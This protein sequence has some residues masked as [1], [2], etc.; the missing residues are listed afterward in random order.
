MMQ[1]IFAVI[2]L[3]SLAA[4]IMNLLIHN[5]QEAYTL[6]ILFVLSAA[7]AMVT[8]ELRTIRKILVESKTSAETAPTIPKYVI[9]KNAHPIDE[10][11]IKSA[12]AKMS[13]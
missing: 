2:A 1:F 5:M 10:K 9:E 11:A 8:D 12:I 6:F 7:G 3:I 13:L 4:G